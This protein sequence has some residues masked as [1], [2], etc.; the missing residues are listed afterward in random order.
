[1]MA[2]LPEYRV[3]QP[4]RPFTNVGC[5]LMGPFNSTQ[6][7]RGTRHYKAWGALFICLATRAVHIELV[8]ALSAEAF[9]AAL[10]RFVARRG[11]PASIHTDH[12]TNFQGTARL[13]Q[14]LQ[15]RNVAN[16][17]G[18][19]WCFIPL[20][21]PHFGGIWEAGVKSTKYHLSRIVENTP[22]T[23]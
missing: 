16:K 7:S 15:A 22:Y 10:H 20:N 11:S 17:E 9:T 14:Q 19:K 5:D 12:G 4:N 3:T 21:A 6:L 23:Y 8:N 1:M 2:D 18:I 13:F